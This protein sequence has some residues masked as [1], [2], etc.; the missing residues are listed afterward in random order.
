[1]TSLAQFCG[2]MGVF[3]FL[4]GLWE[5]W[6]CGWREALKEAALRGCVTA[7]AFFVLGL[8]AGAGLDA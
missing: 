6:F 2:V 1:M 7:F 8:L 3:G 4:S 5:D